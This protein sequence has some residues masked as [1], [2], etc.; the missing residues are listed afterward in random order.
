MDL[1]L[2]PRQHHWT[3][4]VESPGT[5][6]QT[7]KSNRKQPIGIDCV[8]QQLAFSVHSRPSNFARLGVAHSIGIWLQ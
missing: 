8:P 4:I 1:A 7:L 6:N 3:G 5:V 2:S